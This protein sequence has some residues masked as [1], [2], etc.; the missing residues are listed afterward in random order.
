MT[1]AEII[2]FG[3]RGHLLTTVPLFVARKTFGANGKTQRGL[4]RNYD[5]KAIARPMGTISAEMPPIPPRFTSVFHAN[6]PEIWWKIRLYER[7]R[8]SSRVLLSLSRTPRSAPVQRLIGR[9]DCAGSPGRSASATVEVNRKQ[10]SQRLSRCGGLSSQRTLN[11]LIGHLGHERQ[12][13][14]TS[15]LESLRYSIDAPGAKAPNITLVQSAITSEK[16]IIQSGSPP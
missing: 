9:G 1:R 7:A 16:S 15:P 13:C 5:I 6:T 2:K 3:W 8:I 4:W 14:Q 11:I 12:K 10:S